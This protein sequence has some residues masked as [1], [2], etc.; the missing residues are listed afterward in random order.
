M[1]EELG[2]AQQGSRAVVVCVQEGERLLFEEEEGGVEEFEV[3]GEIIQLGGTSAGWVEQWGGE[4]VL[5][6]GGRKHT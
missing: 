5:G 2:V 4:R 1:A 3:F 6:G